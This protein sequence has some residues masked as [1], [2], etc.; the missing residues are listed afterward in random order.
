MTAYDDVL[1]DDPFE[2]WHQVTCRNY[3]VT[4]CRAVRDHSFSA[5]VKVRPFGDLVISQI[6]SQVSPGVELK[7][8][9]G[10]REIRKDYRDDFLVW[11]GGSGTTMLEQGGRSTQLGAGDMILHDQAAPFN[12]TFSQRSAAAMITVPRRVMLTRFPQAEH[13]TALRIRSNLPLARLATATFREIAL[14]DGDVRSDTYSEKVWSA[15][16]DIWVAALQACTP[17]AEPPRLAHRDLRLRTAQRYLLQRLYDPEVN[18]A[19]ASADL[20]MSSRTL[21]RLFATRG[22]TPMHWLWEERLKA[23]REALLRGQFERV[24]DAAFAHGFRNLSHFSRTFKALHG[25][26]ANQLIRE[27]VPEQGLAAPEPT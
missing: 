27:M 24:S 2:R 26:N 16:L 19:S 12:L 21:L 1:P 11:V 18:L 17:G 22:T 4:E 14:Q 20:H 23:C 6:S 8:T 15:A 7:V 13:C 5:Q 9:R 10:R 25:I 3:S